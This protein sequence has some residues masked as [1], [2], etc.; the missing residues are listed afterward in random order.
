M[1]TLHV[2]GIPAP[3]GSKTRTKWG[4]RESSHRVAPWRAAV[5]AEAISVGDRVGLLDALEAPYAVN[6]AFYIQRPRRTAHTH[7]TAPS[8]GDIDKLVRSTLDAL[9]QG[10]LLE[11]DRHVVQLTASKQWAGVD[12]TPGAII[13]IT[14]GIK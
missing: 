9:V 4:M 3:Q 10:G 12:E 2:E 8:I 7:P 5:K 6:C 14:E 13:T 11:D 1:I